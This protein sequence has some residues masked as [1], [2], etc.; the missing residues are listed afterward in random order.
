GIQPKRTI[1]DEDT[2]WFPWPDRETCVLDILRHVPR[3]A[4]SDRQNA[5]IHWALSA[6]GVKDIPSEY[7]MQHISKTLQSL[8]GVSSIRYKGVMG[9]I[10]YVNDFAAIIAQEMANPRVR[11]RLRFL[12]EDAG[13]KLSE[14][15]QGARWRDELDPNLAGPMVR[16][17][18]VDYYVYEPAMLRDG[19]LCMPYRWFTRGPRTLAKAWGL[20]MT[21][22]RS[23]WVVCKHVEFEVDC[24]DLLSSTPT[25]LHTAQY[26]NIPSPSKII[27][28]S[29]SPSLRRCR[30]IL[31][32]ASAGV[33]ERP[34]GGIHPWTLTDPREGNRW[35][36][37]AQGRKV[38]PFPV[39]LYC[40]DTSGN[41]S[42]KW[43]KHNSF[44]FTAAGLPRRFVHREYNIHFLTTSNIAPP[45]EMLD[46]IVEQLRDCQKSGIWAWDCEE[47]DMVLVIPSVLAM[48]G[49]NPMQ[50]EIA[51]HVGLAG[52]L[53]CRVCNVSKGAPLPTEEMHADEPPDIGDDVQSIQ[54]GSEA[55]S[56]AADK[57]SDPRETMAEMV[58]RIRRFMSI[59]SLRTRTNTLQELRSQFTTAQSIGGQANVK[60][61][62]TRTG[63]RD[64]YQ[65]FFID[66]LF[67]LTTKRNRSRQERLADVADYIRTVPWLDESATSPVWRIHDFDP[68]TDTPV[69]ILHVVLLG[70][71][72]YFWRDTI[73]RL[74]EPA[75]ATLIARLS[76]F[77]VA[78]LGI[79]P[80]LGATLVNYAKSL[81]GRDFRA[82]A[83]AA[84]FVLH[85]LDGIPDEL[86]R[87]W[88][89]LGYLV[90]L[91]WQPE[92]DDLPIHTKRLEDAINHFLNSTCNLTPR[93]FNK[94]K[95]HIILHLPEHIRRFGPPMLFAT[96]G[97]E[98][99]NA[100]IRSHS[101]HSNHRAPSRD[102]ALGMAHQNRI[103]HLLSHGSFYMP[104]VVDGKNDEILVEPPAG[105]HTPR[106]PWLR[107]AA[108]LKPERTVWRCIGPNVAALFREEL[109]NRFTKDV[110][111]LLRLDMGADLDR[112]SSERIGL[113]VLPGI[114]AGIR[115]RCRIAT[116]ILLHEDGWY[117]AD[118]QPWV[119]YRKPVTTTGTHQPTAP[120]LGRLR[121]VIQLVGSK[122]EELGRADLL[123][124][125]K[126]QH[127]SVHPHYGMPHI[128]LQDEFVLIPM[129]A[130][131]CV[132]NVQHNCYDRACGL[133]NTRIVRQEHEDTAERIAEVYH[134]EAPRDYI[135]NTAQMRNSALIVPFYPPVPL[136]VDREDLILRAALREF[137]LRP[138]Q[139]RLRA[140]QST[141][142]APQDRSQHE[143]GTATAQNTAGPSAIQVPALATMRPSS[144]ALH[145]PSSGVYGAGHPS[146][147]HQAPFPSWSPYPSNS[148]MPLDRVAMLASLRP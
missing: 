33:Q 23:G 144:P 129:E 16:V 70:F 56:E 9:H 37:I 42:K 68:H 133:A 147:L 89:A 131:I 11:P 40:D 100:V 3:C 55:E 127:L 6:L 22:D 13:K 109:D 4:F 111:H 135:L 122:S 21:S 110:L 52:K 36:K 148:A 128:R 146:P 86:H 51:C 123:V 80:L 88:V 85:N 96:E 45:L 92:I 5:V 57:S 74:K 84:P 53:F 18:G 2:P 72:K 119:T 63:I 116:H 132:A 121:E 93:W 99:F 91:I 34:S 50:S 143:A 124:L 114:H 77:D 126:C 87:V 145:T 139:R 46:G 134:G 59:A 97:F 98:S 101:I 140:A 29:P 15:W 82:I 43:N 30:P 49:D 118:D 35:R 94:P 106:S 28:M 60:R 39:W 7:T 54:S 136:A 31:L 115:S 141:N 107:R 8:C 41:L 65:S 78:G 79:A 69:E 67:S 17:H 108:Q 105:T 19:S 32:M 20:S 25:L 112:P 58:D 125:Q 130:F 83:Q 73:S 76:S 95:F 90:P 27:G 26:Y 38:V 48:L 24:S 66:R 81:V 137:S 62:R 103:R 10:Y 14:A 61:A 47:R 12:P 113:H 75:K 64:A 1:T 138:R 117:K 120:S 142:A 44:L 104:R 102:I 71:I